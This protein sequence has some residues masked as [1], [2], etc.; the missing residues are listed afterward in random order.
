MKE[1]VSGCFFYW[2]QCS[3]KSKT[4]ADEREVYGAGRPS[5]REWWNGR[6]KAE[7]ERER[8]MGCSC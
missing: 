5:V 4:S 8:D 7:R 1:N 2:T 6:T 3:N